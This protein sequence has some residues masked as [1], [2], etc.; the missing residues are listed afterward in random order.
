MCGP[1]SLDR[2]ITSWRS[3]APRVLAHRHFYQPNP[4]DPVV[5]VLLGPRGA[6]WELTQVRTG[7]R[8]IVACEVDEINTLIGRVA[9]QHVEVVSVAST[10]V[11]TTVPSRPADR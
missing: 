1:A 3:P 9:P 7:R 5:A 8:L 10:V 6:R 11:M 2:C 4:A